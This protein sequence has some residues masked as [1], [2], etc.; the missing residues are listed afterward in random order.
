MKTTKKA[1][2]LI[3]DDKP[4]NI[5]VLSEFLIEAGFEV[6]IAKSGEKAIYQL[7]KVSPDLILLDVMMP[8]LNG[9]ETCCRLKASP[10][11]QDIPIIFMTALAESADKVKGLKLGA[12]DYITKPFQQEEVLARIEN[13]LSLLFLRRELQQKNERLQQEIQERE[14]LLQTHRQIEQALRLSKERLRCFFEIT[15]EAVVLHRQGIVVDANRAAE[16]LFGYPV[17]ELKGM[18]LE[19]LTAPE[20]HSLLYERLR[21]PGQHPPTE[22]R[23]LKKDGSLF[24]AEVIAQDINYQGE[25]ARVLGIRDITPAKLT[26]AA[27]QQAKEAAEAASQAK[28]EFLSKMSHELRTPLNAILGYTQEMSRDSDLSADHQHSVE[29]INRSGEHLLA[30]INDVLEMSRIESG[31]LKLHQTDFNL[32]RLLQSLQEML[33]L[34]AKSKGLQ[35]T[36]NQAADLPEWIRTDE[37][38]LR[39]VLINLLG[40]A[41]KFTDT[42][43][44]HLHASIH[45][46]QPATGSQTCLNGASSYTLLIEVEDTGP[47]I[48]QTELD[49]LF[50]AFA[51]GKRG[52]QSQE[53]TGLGLPIS[54]EFV[55]L[56]G[57]EIT[58]ESDLGKGTSFQISLPVSPVAAPSPSASPTTRKVIGLIPGQATYRILVAEDD[59][60]SRL[61][62][63]KMLSSLGFEVREAVNGQEAVQLSQSWVPHLIWMDMQMPVMNGYEATRQIRLNEQ[64]RLSLCALDQPLSTTA[65]LAVEISSPTVTKPLAPVFILALTA[66]AFAEDRAKI[67]A[68]GCDDFVSKPFRRNA[69]LHKMAQYL[70]VG[71]LYQPGDHTTVVK[72]DRP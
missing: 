32:H 69:I 70:G 48:A 26:Q 65:S 40:N 21:S 38:K 15:S 6:L 52:W 42:G 41:I 18:H 68:A 31:Q 43:G 44:I 51:Q 39:Q 37:G 54:R 14:Q 55:K 33:Q 28:S 60:V 50:D 3:V 49:G 1:Q 61:L 66:S 19:K 11:T 12:V 64:Q 25:P 13:Q 63:V 17:E 30:L 9:F 47:G 23:G 45:P 22:A 10:Q 62:M 46:D 36:F 57:G 8:G 29:I 5:R 7:Q 35:L 59:K 72:G 58:V 71:Y 24:W 4:T 2:I 56:M 20:S 67:I 34:K 16:T 53:G 27:L